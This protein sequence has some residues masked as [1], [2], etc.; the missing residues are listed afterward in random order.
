MPKNP[1]NLREMSD[2]KLYKWTAGWKTNTAQHIAGQQEIRRR[3][4]S[5]ASLRSW[6]AIGMSALALAVAVFA[7]ID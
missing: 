6:I 2:D 5:Q 7:L 1:Y 3:N 4:Y